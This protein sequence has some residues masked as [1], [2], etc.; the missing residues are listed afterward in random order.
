MSQ[1]G[2][3]C[4][5]KTVG[6][7]TTGMTQPR[8]NFKLPLRTICSPSSML[9]HLN[10]PRYRN[11]SL[12]NVVISSSAFPSPRPLLL[13]P[14][15]VP[16]NPSGRLLVL[17]ST[18]I[19]ATSL[20]IA[21]YHKHTYP[22]GSNSC[23]FASPAILSN[24]P[25]SLPGLATLLSL[26]RG[27]IYFFSRPTITAHTTGERDI[28]VDH[29]RLA[30]DTSSSWKLLSLIA[31]YYSQLDLL[32]QTTSNMECSRASKHRSI[33]IRGAAVRTPSHAHHNTFERLYIPSYNGL[34]IESI[35]GTARKAT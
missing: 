20:Q 10:I 5:P 35:Y 19:A 3:S 25:I 11:L 13:G 34:V 22:E 12:A 30:P 31:R 4:F 17:S 29:A 26:N 16:R 18:E 32:K 28:F 14:F 6:I 1:P 2:R 21:L 7:P 33:G 9:Y 27:P 23:S 24:I 15:F 8:T